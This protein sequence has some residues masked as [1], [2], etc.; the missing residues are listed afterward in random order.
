M[1]LDTLFITTLVAIWIILLYHIVLAY[2]GYRHFVNSLTLTDL[3]IELKE[4]P[5]VSIM[6]PAHNEEAVIGRTVDAMSRLI[7][8]KDRLQIIVIN[9]NS[10][11]R[12]G[13]ILEEKC[14]K[15]SNLEVLTTDKETGAK[16]KSNALNLGLKLCTGE[17]VVIYDADNTPERHAVLYLVSMILR[18]DSLG[19]VVGKFRTRNKNVNFLTRCINVETLSFQWLLQAGRCHFFG[20]TTIPGT[21]FVIRRSILDDIGGWNVNALTEDTELT[22]RIY[23]SGYRIYWMPHAVTWEQEPERLKVWMKQ[24]TRWAM[25]NMWII[26]HYFWKA[27]KLRSNRIIADIVYFVFTY[28]IFFAAVIVSDVIFILGLLDLTHITIKGPF[29]IV[30]ALAYILFI[31]ETYVSLSLERGEGTFKNL[32]VTA[33]MYFTYSQLW[34]VLIFRAAFM[35]LKRSFSKN[36][37]FKWYKTERSSG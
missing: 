37:E 22:I 31:A 36:K 33:S 32:L 18:D 6:I 8:P 1:T 4:Y 26:W 19:A 2:G 27:S 12:T 29:G 7:Y 13:T 23:D 5:M 34:V 28:F 17:Y 25:G 16:G 14:K 35:I 24:R 20:L 9:D 3:D 11:D 30:W 15:Y 10:S 21:N